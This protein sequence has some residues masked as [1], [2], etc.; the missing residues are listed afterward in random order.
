MQITENGKTRGELLRE[1]LA[2]PDL[3][4]LQNRV[5]LQ[6]FLFSSQTIP[7][8]PGTSD[9]ILFRG[10][11]TDISSALQT[12]TDQRDQ[13]HLK[14]VLL[15]SDGKHNFGEDP[16]R[17][18]RRLSFPIFSITIGESQSR[19]DVILT[20]FL[21]NDITYVGNEVPVEVTL[22]GPGFGGRQ[23]SVRLLR[24]GEVLDQDVLTLPPEGLDSSL[25]LH[26]TPQESGFQKITIEVTRLAGE[27]THINN[28]GE[29]YLRVL[30]SKLKLLFLAGAPSPDLAVIKRLLLAD[31][32]INLVLRTQKDGTRFYEGRFPS[33]AETKT[34]DMLILMDMPGHDLA[35]SIWG[36]IVE[37]IQ[38][39][40]KPFL[41]IMGKRVE[42]QKLR[43][44]ENFLPFRIPQKVSE[45]VVIPR[46]TSEGTDH[47]VMRVHE[48]WET[49]SE[50]WRQLPPLFSTWKIYRMKPG[51]QILMDGVYERG[52]ISALQGNHP[53]ILARH[54][55]EEKSLAILGQGLSR[56][57]L[58]MWGTGG[59]N[60]VLKGFM[61]NSVRW[62]VT[63]EEEKPVRIST[64]KTTY[65]SGE[66]ILFTAQVYD[67][68]YQAK[69]KALV[70]AVIGSSRLQL[71]DVG[72]GRYKNSYRLFES[73]TYRVVVEAAFQGHHLG[74]DTVE[75]SVSSFNP[76]FMDTRADPELMK[77]LA[78]TTQG[79]FGNSDSLS[80]MISALD[81]S[82]QP[83][84]SIKEVELYN[85]PLT[86]MLI[87]LLLTLEWI[88]RKRKGM[89]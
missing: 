81:V 42:N 22:R 62:L 8:Q 32:N 24:E 36:R 87:V 57:D 14:G 80:T 45:N 30:K 15:F 89:V 77:N 43:T 51:C 53:L 85:Y 31:E 20:Q 75:F 71:M 28:T 4:A 33:L 27:T 47:P 7:F 37:M 26:F 72:A 69:S 12:L 49:S 40:H 88:V 41:I 3:A 13:S 50:I 74:K 67:E 60:E 18:A 83:V 79:R 86:L 2:S 44:V 48:N 64:N 35:P 66:E 70:T 52:S 59:S 61:G 68:T 78:L 84:Y 21:T 39:E 82:P 19:P 76:E 10:A 6:S 16:L 17:I 65:Q 63:R 1:L 11:A 55:G 38:Q 73:G 46:I 25:E 29:F 58:L 54:V 23:I 34:V 9:S 56:W 5:H